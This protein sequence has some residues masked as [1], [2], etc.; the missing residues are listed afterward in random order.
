MRT[1]A[2]FRFVFASFIRSEATWCDSSR[3]RA[4][5]MIVSLFS[6]CAS[7]PASRSVPN[8]A[9]RVSVTARWTPPLGKSMCGV[10]RARA[11][12]ASTN[13]SSLVTLGEPSTAIAPAP[14]DC[15]TAFS[16]SA[17]RARASSNGA[18]ISRSPAR[19]SGRERRCF[20][21]TAS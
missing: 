12:C 15:F 5:A 6:I 3:S 13:A 8:A 20:S 11:I 16:A 17:A 4:T 1:M 7:S 21:G 9:V 2:A 10:P 14:A 18:G 19:T